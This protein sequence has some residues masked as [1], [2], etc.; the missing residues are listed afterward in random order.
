MRTEKMIQPII[1]TLNKRKNGT[2]NTKKEIIEVN[3]YK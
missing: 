2:Q 1:N 3:F